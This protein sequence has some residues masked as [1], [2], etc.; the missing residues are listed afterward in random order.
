M[1]HTPGSSRSQNSRSKRKN[2][3]WS[4][5]TDLVTYDVFKRMYWPH[6]PRSSTKGVCTSFMFVSLL[7]LTL[8]M[9]LHLSHSVN[10]L[11]WLLVILLF[12]QPLKP[13]QV[14]SRD[15]RNRWIT[16]TTLLTGRRM[17]ISGTGTKWTIP[18]S[19]RITISSSSAVSAT[20]RIS[21]LCCSLHMAICHPFTPPKLQDAYAT[22]RP[23]GKR[24]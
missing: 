2:Q 13:F 21:K 16:Q 23:K 5:R 1:K 12:L 14:P 8:A 11:V 6:F 19:R 4:G 7:S 20:S 17:K 15:Q 3:E 18:Y 24:A 10:F 22:Q 9:K